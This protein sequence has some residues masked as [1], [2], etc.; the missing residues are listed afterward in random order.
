MSPVFQA[1]WR[2]RLQVDLQTL[3][4]ALLCVLRGLFR[5]RTRNFRL[6]PGKVWEEQA[7]SMTIFAICSCLS[8]AEL[9]FLP[10]IPNIV[11]ICG[12]PGQMLWERLWAWLNF[13]CRQGRYCPWIF[14]NLV[15]IALLM[16]L[17]LEKSIAWD[18]KWLSLS[19]LNHCF[20]TLL[21]SKWHLVTCKA[22]F[23]H[24][25]PTHSIMLSAGSQHSG[26][27]GDGRDGPGDQHEWN[28]HTG[29]CPEQ[30]GEIWGTW[31][32]RLPVVCTILIVI[33]SEVWHSMQACVYAAPCMLLSSGRVDAPLWL[34]SV[35]LLYSCRSAPN[36][37][38]QHILSCTLLYKVQYH[39]HLY[40][41]I[42]DIY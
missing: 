34:L 5:E 19:C 15:F 9:S 39:S 32:P 8:F 36:T 25:L 17:V 29:G 28:H 12:D 2:F 26:R 27:N 16:S 11:G 4:H 20:L 38:S 42:M 18:Q 13:S 10:S 37:G 41:H 33:R 24:A 40:C 14:Y 7:T 35:C 22:S 21:C 1:D 6:N 30:D 31:A 23:T 3:R